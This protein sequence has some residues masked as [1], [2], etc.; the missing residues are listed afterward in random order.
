MTVDE[1]IG[2]L[3]TL[4]TNAYAQALPPGVPIDEARDA[5]VR[6]AIECERQLLGILARSDALEIFENSRHRD[7]CAMP[8]GNQL[9]PLISAEEGAKRDELA[10]IAAELR[11]AQDRMRRADGCPTIID[12]NVWLE[13]EPP[14]QIK[15]ASIVNESARLMVPLR[16]IEEVDAKKYEPKER[17]RDV[18]RRILPWIERLFPDSGCGPVPL[19][20]PDDTTTEILWRIA[21]GIARVMLTRRSLTFIGKSGSWQGERSL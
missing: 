4:S 18:A 5:Y 12:S 13:C 10:E 15:W 16:V 2:I 14:D 6:W 3:T 7:V 21:R 17:L 19:K 8:L 1:A 11:G 20:G 9:R